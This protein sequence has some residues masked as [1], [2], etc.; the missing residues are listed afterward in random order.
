M[1]IIP[2]FDEKYKTIIKCRFRP[3]YTEMLDWVNKNTIESAEVK[4]QY[5]LG[6]EEHPRYI[7]VGFENKDDA[8]VFRIKYSE[9]TV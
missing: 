1:N 2:V 7:C 5:R 4:F 8:L 6:Y 9:E 3:D